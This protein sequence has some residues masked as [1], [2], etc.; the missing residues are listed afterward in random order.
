[1]I[2]FIALAEGAFLIGGMPMYFRQ[3]E[4]IARLEQD[5]LKAE[6]Q[7][8]Q[9]RGRAEIFF[10]ENTAFK[11][12]IATMESDANLS[13]EASTQYQQRTIVESPT[14]VVA[15]SHSNPESVNRSADQTAADQRAEWARQHASDIA[16][17][18]GANRPVV[19]A[20]TSS[21]DLAERNAKISA[22]SLAKQKAYEYFRHHWNPGNNS[23][24]I[25][26]CDITINSIEPKTGWAG[27]WDASGEAYIEYYLSS[28]GSF[29]SDNM[30]FTADVKPASHECS[31]GGV[32]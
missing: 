18:K 28:G 30:H 7:T 9:E 11:Q 20:T 21:D 1:M 32:F 8:V 19:A 27:E 12:R 16:R 13:R 22:S 3:K 25:T 5:V 24:I 23:I 26:K 29:S 15:V 17:A 6:H 10:R 14:P 2:V 31:I 4:D